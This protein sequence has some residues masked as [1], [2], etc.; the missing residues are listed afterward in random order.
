MR[1]PAYLKRHT[2]TVEPLLGMGAAGPQYGPAVE[3]RCL[4]RQSTRLVRNAAGDE[5]TSSSTLYA[6]LETTAPAKSRVTLPDGRRTTV[7]AAVPQDG[8]GLPV[9]DHLEVQLQ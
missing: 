8:G 7:I 3:V 9:P 2:V 6:P 4:L 5:V 1:L